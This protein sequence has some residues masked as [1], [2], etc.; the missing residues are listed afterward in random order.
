MDELLQKD[1]FALLHALME[2][3]DLGSQAGCTAVVLLITPEKYYV[4]NAGDSRC[5]LFSK[6]KNWTPL[7]FDHKPNDEKE[8][9]RIHHAGGIVVEGRINGNL[10]LS[11]AIGDFEFKGNK[12]LKINEQLIIA[13]PDVIVKEFDKTQDFFLMGCDGIWELKNA[14]QLCHFIDESKDGLDK[15]VENLLDSVL[16][17]NTNE[18][19]GCD[20]MSCIIVK[21]L[22]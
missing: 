14:E 15:T 20:N 6:D 19:T 16:A 8:T 2:N 4:A 9:N 21:M 3:T 1:N 5:V 7:S 17:P 11:R 18:G 13:E 22:N 10:N 12:E